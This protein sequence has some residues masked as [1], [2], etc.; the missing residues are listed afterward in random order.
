MR[1]IV[2]EDAE[3]GIGAVIRD[4]RVE[5]E[6]DRPRITVEYEVNGRV[7]SFSFIWG[8]KTDG[9]IRAS[10]WISDEKALVLAAL[11]GDETIKGKR[12]A[13]SFHAKHLFAL[14]KYKGVRWSC[15]GG[16]QK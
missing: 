12:D 15:Y 2:V 10:V 8:V 13:V 16:T 1:D 7:E 11:T 6:G 14:A 9:K 5:R 4:M 3:R